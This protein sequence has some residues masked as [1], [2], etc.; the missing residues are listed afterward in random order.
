MGESIYKLD[1]RTPMRMKNV[2][3]VPC[4]TKNL[5]F[6]SSLDKKGFRVAFIDGEVIMWPKGKTIE[7]AVVIGTEE[8]GLYKLK[9]HSDVAL[10]HST[11]SPCELWYRI[12]DHI[13]YKALP[14]VRK[15][16]TCLPK[17]KVDHEGVC[18]GCAQGKNIKNPFPKSDSKA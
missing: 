1:S 3:Y 15:V 18:K 2:L 9:G 6:I 7:D 17:F 5:L 14:Y 10:T 13:N 11:K 12:L 4:F 16:V 8:G